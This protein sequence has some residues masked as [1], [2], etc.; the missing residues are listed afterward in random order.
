MTNDLIEPEDFP[1]VPDRAT[2]RA[3][4]CGMCGMCRYWGGETETLGSC[5]KRVRQTQ[6]DDTWS[7]FGCVL[8][9]ARK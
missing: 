4:M 1:I 7:D 6:G 9:E 3:L 5:A 8:W 2:H